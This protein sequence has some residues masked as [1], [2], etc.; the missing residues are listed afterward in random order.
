MAHRDYMKIALQLAKIALEDG[1]VPVGAIVVKN[2]KVIGTGINRCE[3][4]K[5]ATA[6][7]EILAIESA[8]K[9]IGDWRLDGCTMYVTLEPCPMCAGAIINSRIDTVVYA[10]MDI[11][12]GAMGGRID[13]SHNVFA[14]NVQ[15]I[16]GVC[17]ESAKELMDSFFSYIRSKTQ[18]KILNL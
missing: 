11:K 7:A 15:T 3:R 16:G 4:D 1:E 10:L 6:H 13:I 2:G 17:E 9:T 14:K 12:G 18:N 5:L 8:S